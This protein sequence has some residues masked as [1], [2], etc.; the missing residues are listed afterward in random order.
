MKSFD[1]I[2]HLCRH[3]E[4]S[5]T[6]LNHWRK[7]GICLD[8]A[9]KNAIEGKQRQ[10]ERDSVVLEVFKRTY[11][12]FNSI[13]KDKR[14]NKHS[15]SPQ[16]I[17][18][19]VDQGLS[20]EDALLKP[21]DRRTEGVTITLPSGEIC[22]YKNIQSA[23]KELT[24]LGHKISP[25]STVVSYLSKGQTVEQAF[26]FESRP[27]ELKYKELDS[28]VEKYGYQ[29]VGDKNEY[30]EPIVAHHEKRIYTS[31]KLFAR[32]YCIDYS[33]TTKKLKNGKTIEEILKES[34][35]LT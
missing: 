13:A 28:L 22:S 35:H 3:F 33:N 31:I 11:E 16:T 26:G 1:S 20:I 23:H 25:Y 9:L 21:N 8:D 12:S 30:S 14:I 15:L 7:K 6:S 17:R 29:F 2:A 10:L 5:N 4:I 18:K 19:R 27:W 34:G 32:T 24:R